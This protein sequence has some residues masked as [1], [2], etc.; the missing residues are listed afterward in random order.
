MIC[1]HATIH[2]LIRV[3]MAQLQPTSSGPG[4]R[5]EYSRRLLEKVYHAHEKQR[6]HLSYLDAMQLQLYIHSYRPVKAFKFHVNG[7]AKRTMLMSHVLHAIK[8]E[9]HMLRRLSLTSWWTCLIALSS[10]PSL[11][12]DKDKLQLRARI[13]RQIIH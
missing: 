10:R 2:I 11:Q 12:L 9:R 7:K 5:H 4:S 13:P 3:C 1:Q 8:K 6:F